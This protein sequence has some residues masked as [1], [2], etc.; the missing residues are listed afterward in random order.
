MN[1]LTGKSIPRRT[2]LRGMG[3]TVALPFLDAMVPAGRSTAAAPPA[4]TRRA[5]VCIETVH[6][7][8]G[9]NEWGASKYLW[10]P[11]TGRQG[12]HAGPRQRAH[13]ARAVARSN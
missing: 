1:F 13:A 5:L 11:E 10:A 8:A 4:P 7:A 6:G 9:S 2:F 12:L 3:A